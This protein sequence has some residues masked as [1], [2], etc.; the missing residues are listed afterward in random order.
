MPRSPK[1]KQAQLRAMT[2]RE[3]IEH[4]AKTGRTVREFEEKTGLVTGGAGIVGPKTLK[5][6]AE[7][8][9]S[10]GKGGKVIEIQ[11]APKAVKKVFRRQERLKKAAEKKEMLKNLEVRKPTK[12]EKKEMLKNLEARKPMKNL[13]EVVEVQPGSS[14]IKGL[15]A[16]VDLLRKALN[17][18][19][20]KGSKTTDIGRKRLKTQHDEK[21]KQLADEQRRHNIGRKKD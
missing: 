14:K 1:K 2:K 15:K 17:E 5:S 19:N 7:M 16:R 10:V 3:E 9:K 6:L 11:K 21:A 8:G 18:A 13:D 4:D 12:N 20:K